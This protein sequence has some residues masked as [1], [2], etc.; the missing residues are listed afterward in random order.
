MLTLAAATLSAARG[1]Y[2]VARWEAIVLDGKALR[3][4]H[5]QRT[6][7]PA[8]GGI[9]VVAGYAQSSAKCWRKRRVRASDHEA[10]LTVALA[11]WRRCP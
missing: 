4:S 10:E 5:G 1:S 7:E 9:D 11:C 8:G 3:G 2:A 6:A